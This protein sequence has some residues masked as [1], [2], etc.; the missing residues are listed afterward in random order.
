MDFINDQ[1]ASV[2]RLHS[3]LAVGSKVLQ[4]HVTVGYAQKN[5]IFNADHCS[6]DWDLIGYA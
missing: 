3:T 2:I 1:P 5:G 6:G 4:L